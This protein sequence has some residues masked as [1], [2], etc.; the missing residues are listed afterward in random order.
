[1]RALR[2]R[3][4]RRTVYGMGDTPPRLGPD[5]PTADNERMKGLAAGIIG[6]V[7]LALLIPR[8]GDDE[9]ARS[10]A[11]R[12]PRSAAVASTGAL[13]Q[14]RAADRMPQFSVANV[15]PGTI[16]E[17]AVTIA[18][19]GS[20]SGFFSLSQTNLTDVRGPGGG[21]LSE[22]LRMEIVDV[23]QPGKAIAVYDGPYAAMDVRPLGFLAPGATRKYEFTATVASGDGAAFTGSSTSARYVWNAVKG[24]AAP[25]APATAPDRR[26][27]TL[28]VRIPAVQRLLKTP[29][30]AARVICTEDCRLSATGGLERRLRADRATRVRI[31]IPRRRL[32]AFRRA[33]VAG[34]SARL[35]L[36]FTAADSAGNRSTVRR[37]V[38]LRPRKR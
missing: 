16:V 37:T 13:T 17:G 21:A 35:R 14:S 2:A 36:K 31:R 8:G 5:R 12:T 24:G 20:A 4:E 15:S 6:I 38:R 28:R 26:A 3:S 19:S 18:N 10:P 25:S 22:R 34:R 9:P 29:Y 23:T 27:P 30:L 1:M 7:V 33:L 32:R 11:E